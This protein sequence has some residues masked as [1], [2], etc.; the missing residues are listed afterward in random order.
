MIKI[1]ICADC[2]EKMTQVMHAIRYHNSDMHKAIELNRDGHPTEELRRELAPRLVASFNEA[3]AAWDAYRDH[4]IGHGLLKPAAKL[5][6]HQLN[7][8]CPLLRFVIAPS[9]S[10]YQGVRTVYD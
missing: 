8:D 5:P 6:T 10:C 9:F 4:L 7:G 1:T 2:T 3:Q